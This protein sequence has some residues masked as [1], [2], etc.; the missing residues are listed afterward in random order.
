[1]QP[2]DSKF[3][4]ES[5]RLEISRSGVATVKGSDVGILFIHLVQ[6]AT[7]IAVPNDPVQKFPCNAI[8]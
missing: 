1:M 3:K 2:A 4:C 5:T 8:S 7:V 6:S